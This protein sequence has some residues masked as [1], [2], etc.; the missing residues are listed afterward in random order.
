[1]STPPSH[2]VNY[3]RGIIMD[4]MEQKVDELLNRMK[5]LERANTQLVNDMRALT[6]KVHDAERSVD[7]LRRP[8][9]LAERIKGT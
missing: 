4:D 7:D 3:F 6:Q 2:G 8:R 9:T 5:H 1:M